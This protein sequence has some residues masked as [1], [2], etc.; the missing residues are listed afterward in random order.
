MEGLAKLF[1]KERKQ[2][3]AIVEALQKHDCFVGKSMGYVLEHKE[4]KRLS[5]GNGGVRCVFSGLVIDIY[6]RGDWGPDS[7]EFDIIVGRDLSKEQDEYL[8]G[9][10]NMLNYKFTQV[11]FYYGICNDPNDEWERIDMDAF[12]DG[13]RYMH[14][15]IN[16]DSGYI[17]EHNVME[18]LRRASKIFMDITADFFKLLYASIQ[19]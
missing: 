14:L 12:E 4:T 11:A 10:V 2:S 7:I 3:D 8:K 17:T 16:Y 1:E 6:C 9:V 18:E 19:K 15:I 5:G 13:T